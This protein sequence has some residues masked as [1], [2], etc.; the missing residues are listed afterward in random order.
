[1]DALGW[2]LTPVSYTHL[3][4][5]GNIHVVRIER[6]VEQGSLSALADAGRNP[7]AGIDAFKGVADGV[8]V[9]C[10]IL[11]GEVLPVFGLRGGFQVALANNGRE[12]ESVILM[13]FDT[14]RLT[15]HTANPLAP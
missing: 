2:R 9:V 4:R 11:G 12:K 3:I 1:M 8:Q 13:S 6:A 14:P 15:S 5:H 10:G 7:F